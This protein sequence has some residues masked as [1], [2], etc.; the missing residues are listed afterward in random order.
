[1]AL[2]VVVGGAEFPFPTPPASNDGDEQSKRAGN[3]RHSD[4]GS[5]DDDCVG[6]KKIAENEVWRLQRQK[7]GMG[8]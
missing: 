4:G 7:K 8:E 6:C 2:E 1:M 5:E 3:A